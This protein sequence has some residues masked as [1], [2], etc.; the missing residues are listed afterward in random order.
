MHDV[1][2]RFFQRLAT[3]DV[4]T[5]VTFEDSWEDYAATHTP[6]GYWRDSTGVVH[7]TGV[8][9]SGDI[10]AAKAIFT[11]PAGYRPALKQFFPVASNAAFGYCQ[12]DEDGA[13]RPVVGNNAWFSV[14][15]ISFRAEQ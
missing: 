8:A 7:L 12:I 2:Y 1:W 9:K 3:Q 4:T 11:L 6:V 14:C 13:V 5:P 10:G 15:G